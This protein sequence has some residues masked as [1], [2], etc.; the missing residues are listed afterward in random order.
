[1]DGCFL[2]LY[3]VCSAFPKY[4]EWWEHQGHQLLY[5]EVGLRK[6]ERFRGCCRCGKYQ[7]P[8]VRQVIVLESRE[9]FVLPG[10][11]LQDVIRE[12]L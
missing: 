10:M 8:P 4:W 9:G 5:W 12:E 3:D 2:L 1:M 7:Y 6:Q 11:G